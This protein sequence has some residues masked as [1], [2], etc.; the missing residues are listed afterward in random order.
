MSRSVT[1]LLAV[2]S[3]AFL[4]GA[5]W[6]QFRG[7]NG[8]SLSPDAAPP[9][10]WSETNN[11]AWKANL[12]GRGASGP[13]VVD[14]RT[15]VTCSSGVKQDRLHVVCFDN[16]TGEEVWQREFWATGRTLTH[17]FSAVAAPTPASDGKRIFA[18]YSSND[19]VCLDLDGNLLWYRGLAFDYPKAGNDIGMASSPVVV[20]ETVVVQIE[21]QG[22]SFAAGIDVATGETR[23][24]V[25]R[26]RRANWVSPIA[27]PGKREGSRVVLLQS[28]SGLT[29]HDS[30]TGEELWRYDVPCSTTPSVAVS[31]DHIFIPANG[32]TVLKLAPDATVPS[33]AW[34]SSQLS[35]SPASPI[36]V[37]DRVYTMNSSGVLSCGDVAT[38]DR[39]WQLR[40]GGKYWS[41]PVVAGDRMYCINSDGAAKVVQLGEKGEVVSSNEFSD[42]IKGSPAISGGALYVRS[43]RFLWKIARGS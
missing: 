14:G 25:D 34:D 36:V 18:F 31:E 6:L 20:G 38:G 29:A 24:R 43:D 17:P 15:Y 30:M 26:D 42:E 40:V 21:N 28:G 8:A 13:I 23:W 3:V 19:L 11:V 41:T 9:D 10:S 39:L 37:G 7:V 33:L 12:P 22:D 35:P 32:L 1:C 5:D 16:R 27:M 2:L 4:C